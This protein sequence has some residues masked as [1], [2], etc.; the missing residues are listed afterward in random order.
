ML[1]TVYLACCI[2]LLHGAVR[3]KRSYLVPWIFAASIA[4]ILLMIAFVAGKDYPAVINFFNGLTIYR[5]FLDLSLEEI[6]TYYNSHFIRV[7]T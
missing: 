1:T 2:L 5:E 7:P 6:N 3:Y 4:A